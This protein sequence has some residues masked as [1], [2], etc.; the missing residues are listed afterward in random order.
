MIYNV[1]SAMSASQ[2]WCPE[3]G[4]QSPV[5]PSLVTIQC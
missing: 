5:T 2:L 4:L 3:D 1:G